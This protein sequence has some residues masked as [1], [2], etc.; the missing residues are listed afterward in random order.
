[1]LCSRCSVFEHRQFDGAR[2]GAMQLP[3]RWIHPLEV[4][5]VLEQATKHLCTSHAH[6]RCSEQDTMPFVRDMPEKGLA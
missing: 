3:G 2:G 5:V 6:R 4:V 1:M